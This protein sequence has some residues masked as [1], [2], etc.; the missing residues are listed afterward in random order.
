MAGPPDEGTSRFKLMVGT[1]LCTEEELS[2][3]A[4]GCHLAGEPISSMESMVPLTHCPFELNRF[5]FVYYYV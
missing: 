2:F 1:A 5:C 3:V 4:F